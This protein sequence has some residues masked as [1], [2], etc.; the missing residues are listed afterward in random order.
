MNT[1]KKAAFC[2]IFFFIFK[3][4]LAFGASL[5]GEKIE[6]PE[7]LNI[8]S[9][10]FRG[11]WV[12]TVWNNFPSKPGLSEEDYKKEY[13]TLLKNLEKAHINTVIFQ[14]RP[15]CDAFYKS[16]G[17]PASEFLTGKQ[18]ENFNFDPL[19]WMIEETHKKGMTFHAWLNPYRV[20]Y[21][22][23]EGSKEELISTLHPANFARKNPGCVFKA[24]KKLYLKPWDEK[25]VIHL[26]ETVQELLKKYEVDAIHFDD[27]FYPA[28][29]F[30]G[31]G[32]YYEEEKEAFEQSGVKNLGDYRRQQTD[33]LVFGVFQTV[34]SYNRVEGKNVEFG[35]SPAGVWRNKSTDP[36]GMEVLTN[37]TSYDTLFADTKKWV[38]N[39]WVDYIVPQ[40]Y[41]QFDTKAA[42]YG[43]CTDWWGK[44]CSNAKVKLYIGHA[45]YKLAQGDWKNSEEL[46]NQLLFNTR[47]DSIYGSFFFNSK[48]FKENTSQKNKDFL[49]K[50]KN[51]IK[52]LKTPESVSPKKE[53]LSFKLHRTGN[54]TLL[55][56]VYDGE[57]SGFKLIKNEMELAKIKKAGKSYFFL[58]FNENEVSEYKIEVEP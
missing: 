55:S 51:E 19:A 16:H 6:L 44:V 57:C 27:Y 36:S 5:Y 25:V 11:V 26:K 31:S 42:P 20:T 29:T 34:Q 15:S 38:E 13:M 37:Y 3:S 7:S 47:Y 35:V 41:W 54:G 52:N 49:E 22:N 58:D 17:N 2:L 40:I 48:A 45:I 8:S 39:R 50:Y 9:L 21:R 43:N 24:G 23:A 1:F 32:G 14:V 46:Y 53:K 56:W 33:N 30:V 10:K 28:S 12:D 4:S 18:G